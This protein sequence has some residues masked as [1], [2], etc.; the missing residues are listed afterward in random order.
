[1]KDGGETFFYSAFGPAVWNVDEEEDES[2]YSSCREIDVEACSLLD[3]VRGFRTT[4]P[5][6]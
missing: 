5:R 3:D 6:G 4:G 1:M 2:N